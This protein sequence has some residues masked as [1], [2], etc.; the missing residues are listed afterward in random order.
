VHCPVQPT[1]ESFGNKN[2]PN[3]L[4]ACLAYATQR[5]D[6]TQKPFRLAGAHN[7]QLGAQVEHLKLLHILLR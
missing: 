4:R 7:V 6:V 2:M 1:G 5:E 3:G